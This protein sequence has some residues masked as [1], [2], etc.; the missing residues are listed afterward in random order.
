MVHWPRLI[1]IYD[2][3]WA[4]VVLSLGIVPKVGPLI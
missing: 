2:M 1:Y 4:N 3:E